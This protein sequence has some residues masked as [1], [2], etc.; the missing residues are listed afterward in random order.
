MNALPHKAITINDDPMLVHCPKSCMASG[1]I[2]AYISALHT[3]MSDRQKIE[4][5][6]MWPL[7]IISPGT[8]STNSD[9]INPPI[10]AKRYMV[11]CVA[12]LGINNIPRK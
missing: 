10:V 4:N 6:A 9:N 2:P 12:Y 11:S 3:P 5:E 7:N 1:H 8:N